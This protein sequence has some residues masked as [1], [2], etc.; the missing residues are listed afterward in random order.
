MYLTT[1]NY[2]E[3]EIFKT[4]GYP[5]RVIKKIEFYLILIGRV[6]SWE[7]DTIRFLENGQMNAFGNGNYLYVDNYT[8]KAYF[9]N[10]EHLLKFNEN[11][12]K[13]VSIRKSDNY[14]VKGN[15]KN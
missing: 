11:Y 3:L 13:F 1:G 12:T 10:N 14:V 6:Y 5:H 7:N 15:L 8:V 4:V 2:M 9:G